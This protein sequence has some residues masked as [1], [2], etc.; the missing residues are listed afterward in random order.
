MRITLAALATVATALAG[1]CGESSDV[2]PLGPHTVV[3]VKLSEYTVTPD[4]DPIE[5]GRIVFELRNSGPTKDHELHII[6]TDLAADGLPT[7]ED[8]SARLDDLETIAHVDALRIGGPARVA[9]EMQP[10]RYV[11]LCNL[12]DS[13]TD[14]SLES[15]YKL[16]MHSVLT[17][18]P[19]PAAGTPGALTPVGP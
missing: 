10:G 4:V 16:R 6:R 5:S 7:N 1:A 13:A 2:T 9:V 12:V 14:G 3:Q 11:L 15:H 18:V 19:A 17:V 8:G